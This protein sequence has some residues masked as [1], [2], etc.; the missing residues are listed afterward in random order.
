M[1]YYKN[2]E[3]V[4]ILLGESLMNIAEKFIDSRTPDGVTSEVEISDFLLTSMAAGTDVFKLEDLV[5]AY[6][7]IKKLDPVNEL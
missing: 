7:R 2:S 6:A 4:F 1:N 5:E 3:I